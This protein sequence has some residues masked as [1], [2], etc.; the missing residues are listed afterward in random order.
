MLLTI[1]MHLDCCGNAYQVRQTQTLE[2]IENLLLSFMN[3][4]VVVLVVFVVITTTITTT[5]TCQEGCTC[6]ACVKATVSKYVNE[7]WI[8]L[9]YTG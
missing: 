1:L 8:S 4:L 9:W 5:M 6:C 7:L 3:P 2:T